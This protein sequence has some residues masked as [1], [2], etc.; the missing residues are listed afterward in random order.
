MSQ[1]YH[2]RKMTLAAIAG[3]LLLGFG[4][5]AF[6]QLSTALTAEGE[7]A[8]FDAQTNYLEL[9][10]GQTFFVPDPLTNRAG[11]NLRDEVAIRYEVQ[12]GVNVVVG[13]NEDEFPEGGDDTVTGSN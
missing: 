6:A 11:L 10:N 13:L 7:I 4:T 12:N 9:D 8:A 5:G 1:E 2:M 3:T